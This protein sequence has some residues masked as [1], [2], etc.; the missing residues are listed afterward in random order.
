MIKFLLRSF[1]CQMGLHA[2]LRRATV[3]DNFANTE[4]WCKY[5][6]HKRAWRR[7]AACATNPQQETK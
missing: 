2:Y 3:N 7:K 4:I 5:C 6:P 1:M